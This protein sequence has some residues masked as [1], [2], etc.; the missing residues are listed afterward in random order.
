MTV[1]VAESICKIG[2]P[3]HFSCRVTNTSG[4]TMDLMMN[5]KTVPKKGCAHTGTIEDSL[6]PIEPEKFKFSYKIPFIIFV[7]FNR[8]FNLI[9]SH[10]HYPVHLINIAVDF[11]H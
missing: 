3:F 7:L 6:G 8:K 1:L 5:L 2:E 4:R 10:I 11:F 9:C